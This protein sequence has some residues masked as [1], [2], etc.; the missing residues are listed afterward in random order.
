VRLHKPDWIEELYLKEYINKQSTKDYYWEN[1]KMVMTENYHVNRG[2][3][4]KNGCKHCPYENS[5][6]TG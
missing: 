3:C 2:Y 6:S 4:C 5:K 1:G